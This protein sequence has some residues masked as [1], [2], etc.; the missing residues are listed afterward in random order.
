M[1]YTVTRTPATPDF[2][3]DLKV[4]DT[5]TLYEAAQYFELNVHTLRIEGYMQKYC[6]HQGHTLLCSLHNQPTL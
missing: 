4:G 1:T 2:A 6:T 3:P 5:L